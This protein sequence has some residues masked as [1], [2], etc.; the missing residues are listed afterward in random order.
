MVQL[1]VDDR[2]EEMDKETGTLITTV[3]K[4][5]AGRGTTPEM[6]DTISLRKKELQVQG[7]TI[8]ISPANKQQPV[9]C[10]NVCSQFVQF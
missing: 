10:T 8:A 3:G 4:D 2:K 7:T 6:I 9:G 1:A 5:I